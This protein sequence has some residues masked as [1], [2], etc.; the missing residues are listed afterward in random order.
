MEVVAH[1]AKSQYFG[2]IELGEP[3]DQ[4]QQMILFHRTYGKFVQGCARHDMIY[5]LLIR[6]Y[7]ARCSW[8]LASYF[9]AELFVILILG[10]PGTG[11]LIQ[12]FI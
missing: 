3:F 5:R 1:Q 12:V 11:S 7:H 2:K 8:H 6:D 9:M 4:L 10:R